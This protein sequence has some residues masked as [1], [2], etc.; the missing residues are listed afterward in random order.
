MFRKVNGQVRLLEP[1][2]HRVSTG[3][4]VSV[5]WIAFSSLSMPVSQRSDVTFRVFVCTLIC[6]SS[7]CSTTAQP[8]VGC[9]C[10]SPV[11]GCLC[12]KAF[13]GTLERILKCTSANI[14]PMFTLAL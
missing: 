2:R 9:V 14:Q 10:L 1:P 6:L 3:V 13:D 4:M 12:S 5:C 11:G 8:G 7:T